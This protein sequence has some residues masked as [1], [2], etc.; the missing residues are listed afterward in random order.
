M[1]VIIYTELKESRE[2]RGKERGTHASVA[3]KLDVADG[4]LARDHDELGCLLGQ[5][6]GKV[7][8]VLSVEMYLHVRH[9][10]LSH[11]SRQSI[12]STVHKSKGTTMY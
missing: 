5:A 3:A 8:N 2:V 10:T 1:H 9:G 7:R 4:N 12:R 11:E 6:M